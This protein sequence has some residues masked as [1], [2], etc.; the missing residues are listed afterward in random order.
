LFAAQ[1]YSD[2]LL[3]MPMSHKDFLRHTLEATSRITHSEQLIV[4]LCHLKPSKTRPIL[5]TAC[6]VEIKILIVIEAMTRFT[7]EVMLSDFSESSGIDYGVP[8]TR[9]PL[10]N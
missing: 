3:P 8:P 10:V 7:K 5:P 4:I 2:Q 1:S 9:E 6:I